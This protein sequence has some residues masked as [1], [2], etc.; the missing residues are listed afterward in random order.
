V[1]LPLSVISAA[2]TVRIKELKDN[3]RE[4]DESE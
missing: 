1:D 2:F 3:E 4:L